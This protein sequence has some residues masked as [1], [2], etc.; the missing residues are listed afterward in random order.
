MRLAVFFVFALIFSQVGVSNAAMAG[1]CRVSDLTYVMP[2]CQYGGD[3]RAANKG[4]IVGNQCN[5]N[6]IKQDFKTC[7]KCCFKQ[8]RQRYAC[9]T[10]GQ[11]S[12]MALGAYEGCHAACQGTP[13]PVFSIELDPQVE[14]EAEL[15]FTED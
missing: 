12:T 13:F 7:E 8:D 4:A 6:V 14:E 15:P 9:Y 3:C 1:I 10:Q 5:P 11:P 2:G